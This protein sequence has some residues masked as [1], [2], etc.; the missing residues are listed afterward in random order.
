MS[1]NRWKYLTVR[2]S[3]GWSSKKT[4]ERLQTELDQY[5]AQG[6]E[7]TCMATTESAVQ[8]VFRKPA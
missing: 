2:V 7:L 3:V 4:D 8:L 6:W 5:G 1:A